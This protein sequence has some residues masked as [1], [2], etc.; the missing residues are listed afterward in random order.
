MS[1]YN[2]HSTTRGKSYNSMSWGG[3]DNQNS[4]QQMA[5]TTYTGTSRLTALQGIRFF[6]SAGTIDEGIFTL[7]GVKK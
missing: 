6:F 7:Y 5:G 1:F 2:V 4:H 3:T